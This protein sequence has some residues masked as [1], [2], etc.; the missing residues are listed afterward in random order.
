MK[1]YSLYDPRKDLTISGKYLWVRM[2]I[3]YNHSSELIKCRLF[4]P[5]QY[6]F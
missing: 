6:A 2:W 5:Q 4:I 3:S 1:M